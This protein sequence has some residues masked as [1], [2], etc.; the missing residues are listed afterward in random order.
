M[1]RMSSRFRERLMRSQ[2]GKAMPLLK[3][4][5]LATQRGLYSPE[6]A[7]RH[8]L[9]SSEK[10]RP[11]LQVYGRKVYSQNDEDGILEYLFSRIPRCESFFVEIGVGPPWHGG[12]KQDVRNTGLECNSRLLAERGW[13]G[14]F[15]D[16]ESYPAQLKVKKEFITAENINELLAKYGVPEDFD[17]FSLDIDGNDYWVWKALTYLPSVVVIEYNA[18]IDVSESK[19]MPYDPKFDW[20]AHGCTKYYGASLLAL[21]RLGEQKGYSLVYANGINAF[22][23]RST[24]VPNSADFV[25]EK[26]YRY[27]DGHAKLRGDEVWQE[28]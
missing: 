23:V 14:L 27:K 10:I 3:D 4:V 12:T 13:R 9:V 20:S 5:R 22:F 7:I 16:G 19:T 25:Y 2:L 17:L 24:L 15:I 1:G 18:S 8:R 28:V 6:R 21:K 26:I 11:R